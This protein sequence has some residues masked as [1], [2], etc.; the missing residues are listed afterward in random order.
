MPSTQP[1]VLIV[2]D[3]PGVR[4]A[5]QRGLAQGGFDT[6]AVAVAREALG[7]D[8]HDVALVDL[9]LPDG[10]GVELCKELRARH[11]DR[12]IIVV[13]GR[14]DEVDVVD[15]LDAGADDYVTKPFSL[16]VLTLRI[17]RHLDRSSGVVDV[18]VLRID[19]R[20]RRATVAGE[21]VEL[22]AREFDL[23]TAL[24]ARAG[25]PVSKEDLMSEV[26]D[27]FWSKST[28][29]LAV[30]ISSLRA[31]LSSAEAD[32]PTIITVAGG[33]YRLDADTSNR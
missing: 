16:A 20:A 3:E 5:L 6:T 1:K 8:D 17:R 32:S 18:G 23:L 4:H 7:V 33:G 9:G 14:R 27:T 15:A 10:D 29:T 31:K 28:H 19:R 2:E 30:H 22:T 13:T 25:Q 26:W 12:P 24:A 11:P 21:P